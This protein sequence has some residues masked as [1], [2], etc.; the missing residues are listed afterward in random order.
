MEL[1][2]TQVLIL[3]AL[4]IAGGFI[5]GLFGVGGGVI[6]IPILVLVMGYSQQLAQGTTLALMLL[7]IG[8]VA[9][10]QYYQKGFVN[11]TAAAIMV[12]TFVI[13]SYFGSKLAINMEP[14]SEVT[15]QH[16]EENIGISKEYNIFEN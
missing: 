8:I 9:T 16:I 2:S 1:N 13:G 5:S 12:V 4:G 14:G 10:I 7:P 3:L 15:A 11:I 6:V